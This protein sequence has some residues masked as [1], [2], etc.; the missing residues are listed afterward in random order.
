MICSSLNRPFFMS[1]SFSRSQDLHSNWIS[2]KG[3]GQSI[4]TSSGLAQRKCRI[5]RHQKLLFQQFL[6]QQPSLD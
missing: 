2:L 6:Q 4:F 1:L 5:A 3:A